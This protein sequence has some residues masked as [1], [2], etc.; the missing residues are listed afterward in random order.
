MHGTHNLTLTQC[1]K[2]HGTHSV[3]STHCNM[4]HG[5]HNVTL[6]HCNMMHGTHNVTSTH[7]NMM[8]GTHNVTLT[9]RNMMHGTRV[10]STHFNMMHGTHVTF[11]FVIFVIYFHYFVLEYPQFLHIILERETEFHSGTGNRLVMQIS[12]EDTTVQ[13][14]PFIWCWLC[15][16]LN[17]SLSLF[18]MFFCTVYFDILIQHKP[19]K[20]TIL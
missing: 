6:T 3:T 9:H 17:T 1:N 14:V 11:I 20:C 15:Y 8:H 19:T 2:M 13:N 7:F 18:S 12:T 4:M 16:W 5:T 10:T